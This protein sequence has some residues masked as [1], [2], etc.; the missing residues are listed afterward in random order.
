MAALNCIA[1]QLF[2]AIFAISFSFLTYG[3]E[4]IPGR[5]WDR[6]AAPETIGWSTTKL[7]LADQFARGLSTDAYLV[8]DQGMLIHEYGGTSRAT[9]VHSIR[10]SVLSLLIGVYADRGAITLTRSM[11]DLDINDR[12]RLSDVERQATIRQL[13]Q[14]RSGI[15]HPAAYETKSMAA[16]RPARES[17]APGANFYYNNWDFNALGTIFKKLTNKTVFEALRDDL[18]G[19]LQF[20]SFSYSFDTRFHNE[21]A[22][23][24]P[25]Y[26]MRFSA[27]DMAR[28]GLLVARNGRWGDRQ[29]VSEKWIAE[30][31]S[32][33]SDTAT[34][35]LGY[36]Y[37]WWIGTDERHFGV[38]FPGKVVSARGSQ[39][40]YIVVDVTRGIIVVHKVNSESD[41]RRNVSGS[42]F[43]ELLKRI[44]DA[45]S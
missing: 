30:S 39:G 37:L 44:M 33:Y 32:S 19:P 34:V 13:M 40:Q 20:E 12:Y 36:G 14:A 27:R 22:S 23:E 43:G 3:A 8:V 28:L 6:P 11:A 1:K 15:Y 35:G 10:K 25:A 31:L 29:I 18:A 26:I 2:P 24:H 42:E 5:T 41:S 21:P 17:F 7:Q 16:R 4:L 9:N 38:P 45:K